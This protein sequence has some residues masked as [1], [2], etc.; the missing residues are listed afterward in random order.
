MPACCDRFS[1]YRVDEDTKAAF[2][3]GVES[4]GGCCAGGEM[5]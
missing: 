4:V 3:G 5:V 2:V 1:C